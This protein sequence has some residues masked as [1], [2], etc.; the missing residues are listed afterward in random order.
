MNSPTPKRPA[1]LLPKT[2]QCVYASWCRK[3]GFENLRP[4]ITPLEP[5][6]QTLEDPDVFL[7]TDGLADSGSGKA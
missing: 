2:Q 5:N 7:E 6:N 3:P 1:K 4:E